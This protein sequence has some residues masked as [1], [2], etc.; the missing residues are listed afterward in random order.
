VTEPET[1]EAQ[2]Q[3]VLCHWDVPGVGADAPVRIV[4]K[5]GQSTTVVGANGSG[6]S[7]LGLWM[8][9]NSGGFSEIRRLIAH[10]KLWFEYAG[11]GITSAQRE[12]T[13]STVINW[14]RQHE[15]RYLDHADS[16]RA[17][18]VLFDIL[19]RVNHQ[20]ARMVEMY[21]RNASPQEVETQLGPPF[22]DRLNSIF[23]AAGLVIE[24]KLTDAQTLNAVNSASGA[25]Y[26][27]FQMSD[28]EKS[29]LLLAGEV[30]TTAERSIYIID[31]PERHL[32]R[33]I[34]AGLV[35][36]IIADRPGS[37]F[38][39]LTHDLE[40]AAAL[41]GGSGQVY[42]LTGCTWTGQGADGWRL[43]PV[44][45]SDELPE[46]ARLAIL[47]G[48]RQLLFL[49]GDGHSLDTRLYKLLFPE[50]TLFPAGGCNEVIRAVTGLRTSQ[51]H[52]WLSARGVVDGDGRDENEKSSLRD[53]GILALPVS[54]VENL[55]YSDVVIR[56]VAARQAESVDESADSLTNKAKVAALQALGD[57]GTPERLAGGLA[58]SMSRRRLLQA[59][60]T[61]IDATLPSIIVNVPSPYPELLSRITAL[62]DKA[63][64]DGLIRLLPI[65]DTALRAQVARS[66][67]FQNF[68]DYEAAARVRIRNDAP[69]A[70]AVR[71]LIGPMPS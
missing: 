16:Q 53:R 35:E 62:L 2:G 33:S 12:S 70:A 10:R 50:W 24:L 17:S 18:I 15:S 56:A 28:G 23:R 5:S 66:L 45:E 13:R 31:E 6:K 65:R 1:A 29:A 37:H 42:S 52:H 54:E 14:S 67:R 8:Q 36:A 48:R 25:E 59:L 71:G 43:F 9:Q 68:A 7:A 30:L 11:P 32:H 60:P 63:D 69:L 49:E 64:L 38:V 55:Y 22:L 58:L 40:L 39:V 21:R 27:I 20:N 51:P 34:S 61:A 46:S 3:G 44:D 26:P 47:G 41:G 4:A 19:A 57:D